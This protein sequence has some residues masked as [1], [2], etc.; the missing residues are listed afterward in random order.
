MFSP[1]GKI[2]LTLIGVPERL[3]IFHAGTPRIVFVAFL[4]VTTIFLF[5]ANVM[6][7][8]RS[9]YYDPEHPAWVAPAGR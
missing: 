9:F 4:K 5:T 1:E 3:L 6:L 8:A 2:S 7:N